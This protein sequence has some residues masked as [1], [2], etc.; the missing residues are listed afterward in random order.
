MVQRE[1]SL[2]SRKASQHLQ[3]NRRKI[4]AA[5]VASHEKTRRECRESGEYGKMRA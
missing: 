2:M 5:A 3:P 4:T 1:E